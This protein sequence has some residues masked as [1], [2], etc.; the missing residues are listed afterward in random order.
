MRVIEAIKTIV[1]VDCND[2]RVVGILWSKM[3]K[4]EVIANH[5]I[6]VIEAIKLVQSIIILKMKKLP[7]KGENP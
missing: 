7:F 4:T 1:T 6:R 5:C 2:F 3:V